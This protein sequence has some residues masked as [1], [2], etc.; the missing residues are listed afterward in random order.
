M[1]KVNRRDFL[2]LA[3]AGSAALVAVGAGVSG[4]GRLIRR[5]SAR[6]VSKFAF[7]AT[8]GLPQK[9]PFPSYASMVV[10]GTVD[11]AAGTGSIQRSI[12]AGAPEAMSDIVL[13]GTTR[14]F[15]VTSVRQS[16]SSLLVNAAIDDA[17]TLG[18][19]ESPSITLG[20]DRGS[21]LIRAPFIDSELE[22]QSAR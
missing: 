18:P 8:A 2:K 21:G 15:H 22:L 3:G 16:R 11:P 5:G 7:R 12:L 14:T 6:G 4:V 1:S 13:P 20:I 10:K 19:G 17:S 9:Y